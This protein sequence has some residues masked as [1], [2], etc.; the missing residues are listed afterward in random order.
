MERKHRTKLSKEF[1]A[2]LKGKKV[3]CLDIPDDFGF[4]DPALVQILRKKV[5]KHLP[6]II[7]LQAS[8]KGATADH[9]A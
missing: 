3:V 1:G 2:A 6:G 9:V 7:S 5:P 4:M 8:R